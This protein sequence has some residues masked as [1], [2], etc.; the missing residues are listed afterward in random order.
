MERVDRIVSVI[1]VALA[2]LG[3]VIVVN[4]LVTPV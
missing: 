4:A 1:F 3:S 2:V